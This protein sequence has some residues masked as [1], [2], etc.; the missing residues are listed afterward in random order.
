[1]LEPLLILYLTL[2]PTLSNIMGWLSYKS[3]VPHDNGVD[4]GL[5]LKFYLLAIKSFFEPLQRK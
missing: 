4:L 2:K 5:V 1:M 3:K